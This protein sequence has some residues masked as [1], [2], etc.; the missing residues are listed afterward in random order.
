MK[1][2]NKTPGF[3]YGIV[4]LVLPFVAYLFITCI[5]AAGLLNL[6]GFEYMSISSVIIFFVFYTAI[7]LIV[8]PLTDAYVVAVTELGKFKKIFS[9]VFGFIICVGF[10]IIV[11]SFVESMISGII[12]PNRTIIFFSMITYTIG[13]IL[14]EIIYKSSTEENKVSEDKTVKRTFFKKK[15]KRKSEKE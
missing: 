6:L 15:E 11:I 9:E 1:E 8:E 10:D 4:G 3:F 7:G 5:L 13:K 2:N 12:I 14:E